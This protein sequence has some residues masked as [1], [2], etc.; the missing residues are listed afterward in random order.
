MITMASSHDFFIAGDHHAARSMV[1]Q[2]LEGLGY[3]IS[4]TRGDGILADRGSTAATVLWGAMA[5]KKFRVSFPVDFMVDQRGLLVARL[6]RS[7]MGGA[8]KGGAIG[9][10]KTNSAFQD[11]ADAIGVAVN[12]AGL[13]VETAPN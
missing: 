10:A 11:A 12:R 1:C 8:L 13:L 2:A 4:P 5:G 7:L 9:A 3:T 6:N